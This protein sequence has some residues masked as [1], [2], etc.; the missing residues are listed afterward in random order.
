MNKITL[1]S[2]DIE[3]VKDYI[4]SGDLELSMNSY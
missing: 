2:T 3:A 4:E 1:K